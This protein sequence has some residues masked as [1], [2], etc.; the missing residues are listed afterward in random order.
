MKTIYAT[1]LCSLLLPAIGSAGPAD[2]PCQVDTDGPEQGIQ[3]LALEELWRV[4]GEDEDV[5]FGRIVDVKRGPQGNT[6][7]LDNQLCQVMVFSP[8]GEHL[9][10]LS[11]EGDGPG[12]LRQ[13]V[14]LSFLS[15][16]ILGIGMG[17]PG[18]VITL[19][20]DGTPD[21]SYYPIGVPSEGNLGILMGLQYVNGT[22]MACGG[23]MV[24][25]NNGEGHT[26]RFLS[27][28]NDD[29]SEV[30]HILEK[31]T[32]LDLTGRRFVEETSYFVERTWVLSPE[33]LVY[34]ATKRNAYEILVLD[35]TGT[36][37]KSFGRKYQ[38]RKRTRAEKD[39]I[40]PMINVNPNADLE[41]DAEDNDEC[42][43]RIIYNHD[44]DTIWVLT[45]HGD[46]EQSGEILQVWDVF[47]T[48]GLYLKQVA[49][50]LGAE[51]NDGNTYLLGNNQMIVVK[52]ASSVFRPNNADEENEDEVEPLEVICYKI[53]P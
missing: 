25:G 49:I 5:I 52:G 18:K 10:D 28:C 48:E 11:R 33:G 29:C 2:I 32:P 30:K 9:R 47:N 4:G 45:P 51:M 20:L 17:F 16:D 34:A 31:A 8:E 38:P 23:R 27:V 35:Q 19:K 1:I 37:L 22:M 44:E 41:V 43:T 14:Q 24:F 46:K 12:E 42:I 50:P 15:D 36:V 21:E 3:T 53:L 13:P 6:Y 39:E 7:V 26:D 40:S